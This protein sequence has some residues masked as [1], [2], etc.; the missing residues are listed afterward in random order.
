MVTVYFQEGRETADR[1]D[2][3]GDTPELRQAI[4]LSTLVTCFDRLLA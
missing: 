3:F 2:I 4:L 1:I